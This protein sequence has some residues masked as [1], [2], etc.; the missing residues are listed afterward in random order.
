MPKW[1]IPLLLGLTLLCFALFHVVL[2]LA[3]GFEQAIQPNTVDAYYFL[4]YAD[5]WPN[6]PQTDFFLSYPQG[7]AS[8]TEPFPAL[9]AVTSK[10]FNISITAAGALIP[11]VLF[12]LTLVAVYFLANAL[13][14]SKLVAALGTLLLSIMPG[15]IL[16]RTMLGASDR[17]CLEI[18]LFTVAMMFAVLA[19]RSSRKE[20]KAIFALGGVAFAVFYLLSWQGALLILLIFAVFLLALFYKRWWA[21]GMLGVLASGTWLYY[22]DTIRNAISFLT[23]NMSSTVVEMS[24]LIFT[25]GHFDIS[26]I[27]VYFSIA[28]FLSL[29]GIGVLA[30]Q[31]VRTKD[32]SILLFL[33]WSVVIITLTI[34]VRRFAYYSAINIALLTVF[35]SLY[36][37]S[38]LKN[39]KSRVIRAVAVLVIALPLF[40]GYK[41]TT[42]ALSD[43]GKMPVE[44]QECCAWLDNQARAEELYEINNLPDR[45]F[46]GE[47]PAYAALSHWNYGYWIAREGHTAVS[48]TPGNWQGEDILCKTDISEDVFRNNWRYIILDEE[49][50]TT[51][52]YPV[53]Y[54]NGINPEGTAV[55]KLFYF[56]EP[57]WQS[58]NGKVKIYE[59]NSN[60]PS[61]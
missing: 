53:F 10:V 26:A 22:P 15:E 36:I 51:N 49:M 31:Y 33:V 4:R 56:T 18:F 28:F 29:F 45:Y 39:N 30:K 6:L 50:F 40:F 12:L 21:W 55:Y 34:S 25:S 46:T 61:L 32:K 19:L 2:P 54:S 41:S 23:P 17:H 43:Y 27:A 57:T 35:T 47:F 58:S 13:F 16:H 37:I 3:Q 48:F 11:P 60:S 1:L 59:T 14:K 9:I 7:A 52:A 24:P 44:W 8:T 38:L 20:W 42:T 5:I